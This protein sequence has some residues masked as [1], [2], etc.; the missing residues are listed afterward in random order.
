[1]LI[2]QLCWSGVWLALA[3]KNMVQEEMCL[4]DIGLLAKMITI[5]G[6]RVN[7]IGGTYKSISRAQGSSL[8]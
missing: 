7:V 4:K 2:G 8:G 6:S 5:L 1:M 3:S